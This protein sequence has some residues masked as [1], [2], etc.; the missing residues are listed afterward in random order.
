MQFVALDLET[1]GLTPVIDQLVEIG[2]IR[3][4]AGEVLDTFQTL[5]DPE[6]PISPGATATNGIT[7]DH[8]KYLLNLREAYKNECT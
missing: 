3:F 8:V 5:V 2:A 7:D 6:I 4:R 1:S